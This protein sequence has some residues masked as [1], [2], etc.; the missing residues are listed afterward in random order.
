MPFVSKLM[1]VECEVIV[2]KQ[3]CILSCGQ[4]KANAVQCERTL[5]SPVVLKLV[6]YQKDDKQC[7]VGMCINVRYFEL[8][9]IFLWYDNQ[10]C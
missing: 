8:T 1:F 5:K 2:I 3:S 9:S 4:D 7:C 6:F 10:N